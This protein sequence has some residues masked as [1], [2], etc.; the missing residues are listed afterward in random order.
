MRNF[1]HAPVE[2]QFK[3]EGKKL[4]IDMWF[5]IRKHVSIV[6]TVQSHIDNMMV[7]V[8]QVRNGHNLPRGYELLRTAAGGVSIWWRCCCQGQARD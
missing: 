3:D 6:K 8:V 2:M 5:G 1:K 4:Q 7:G